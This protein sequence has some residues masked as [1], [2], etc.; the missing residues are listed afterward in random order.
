MEV[1][2]TAAEPRLSHQSGGQLRGHV[3]RA[4]FNSVQ[5]TAGQMS[6]QR[7]VPG[8]RFPSAQSVHLGHDLR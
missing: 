5:Q 2:E 8:G 3:Q 4:E 7:T 6:F 1:P